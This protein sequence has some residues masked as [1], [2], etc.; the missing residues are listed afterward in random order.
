MTTNLTTSEVP[1]LGRR[2]RARAGFGA[3]L[4]FNQRIRRQLENDYQSGQIFSN[5]CPPKALAQ[6]SP[7]LSVGTAAWKPR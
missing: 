5:H 7:V 2:A 3:L 6:P 1:S 4:P